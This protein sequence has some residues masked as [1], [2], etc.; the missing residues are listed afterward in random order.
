MNPPVGSI[1]TVLEDSYVWTVK[2]TGHQGNKFH[3][4]CHDIVAGMFGPTFTVSAT[5]EHATWCYGRLLSWWPPHRAKIKTMRAALALGDPTERLQLVDREKY[6]ADDVS[7]LVGDFNRVWSVF[8]QT[9][10]RKR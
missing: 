8:Q 10:T 2:V 6:T 3:F 7:K 5:G 9:L 4:R 1:L